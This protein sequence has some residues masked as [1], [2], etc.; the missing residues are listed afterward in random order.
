MKSDSIFYLLTEPPGFA[1][2]VRLPISRL[3]CCIISRYVN[4]ENTFEVTQRIL[5]KLS[6]IDCT[7]GTIALQN[8]GHLGRGHHNLCIELSSQ[9]QLFTSNMK[10]FEPMRTT[11]NQLFSCMN[12]PM[13]F[14]GTFVSK[15]SSSLVVGCVKASTMACKHIRP[16]E[17]TV[18]P[19]FL[20]PTIG[21]PISCM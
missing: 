2:S 16:G 7:H 12:S 15:R 11:T 13:N 20:S 17:V 19:Y 3:K 10:L 8:N 4:V 18:E 1:V 9:I 21:C 5:E 6:N 14:P